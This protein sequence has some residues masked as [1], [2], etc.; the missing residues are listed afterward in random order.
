[1]LFW[2]A[3]D[4]PTPPNCAGDDGFPQRTSDE[5][6]IFIGTVARK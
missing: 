1:M 2:A 6:C 4:A 3:I 5:N